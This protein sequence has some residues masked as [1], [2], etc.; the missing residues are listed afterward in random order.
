[1]NEEVLIPIEI[2]K[3][4]WLKYA[5]ASRTERLEDTICNFEKKATPIISQL[6]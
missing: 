5:P 4:S 6:N 3:K 1:M 2:E